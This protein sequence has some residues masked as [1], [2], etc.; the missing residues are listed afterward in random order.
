L[1]DRAVALRPRHWVAGW[2]LLD[3]WI[4]ESFTYL[5]IP[6]I[7]VSLIGSLVLGIG[8]LRRR[9]RPRATGWLLV[10]FLPLAFVISNLVALGA[11]VLPTLWAWGLAGKDLSREVT[12]IEAAATADTSR[13]S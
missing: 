12:T 1:V 13:A 11:A 7:L 9:V 8:L 4:E 5:G 3:P 10:L 6:G 2:G